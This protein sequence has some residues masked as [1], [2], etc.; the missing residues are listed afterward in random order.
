R[1]VSRVTRRSDG[2]AALAAG[3]GECDV[4]PPSSRE[5]P[6]SSSATRVTSAIPRP[7]T[8]PPAAAA[9]PTLGAGVLEPGLAA[10]DVGGDELVVRLGEVD[11]PLDHADQRADA[12][13][14]QRDDDLDDPLL[15]V[16]EVELV[17]AEAA[18]HD[19]EDAGSQLLLG[20]RSLAIAHHS[21]LSRNRVFVRLVVVVQGEDEA[22]GVGDGERA[23]PPGLGADLGGDAGA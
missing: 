4:R 12:A 15:L 9:P 23:R 19:A 3:A 21:L 8:V 7:I 18:Q 5:Q 20:T 17:D 10:V 1:V 11:D 2:G 13:G 16:A 14:Q 22:V 6:P